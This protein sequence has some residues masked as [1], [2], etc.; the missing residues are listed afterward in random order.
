MTPSLHR[1]GT[2]ETTCCVAVRTERMTLQPF[3]L[4]RIAILPTLWKAVSNNG[5]THLRFHAP[6]HIFTQ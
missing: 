6:C 2:T 4:Q 5:G 3:P 1:S